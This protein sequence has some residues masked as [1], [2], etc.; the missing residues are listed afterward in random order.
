MFISKTQVELLH[1]GP[2]HRSLNSQ[3][4]Q[5]LFEASSVVTHVMNFSSHV[6]TILKKK[7]KT[8]QTKPN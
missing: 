6:K 5:L 8:K 4:V 7:K 3:H 1:R 2:V